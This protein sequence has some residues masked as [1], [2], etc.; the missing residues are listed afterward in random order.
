[1]SV[2][3]GAALI[4]L[5]GDIGGHHV[6]VEQADAQENT[7]IPA[8]DHEEEKNNKITIVSD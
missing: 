1:M 6:S 3:V 5:D 4:V 2:G 7:I 8:R